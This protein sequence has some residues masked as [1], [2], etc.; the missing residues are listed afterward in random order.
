MCKCELKSWQTRESWRGRPVSN[1]IWGESGRERERDSWGAHITWV[2]GLERLSVDIVYMMFI[3]GQRKYII[4][5]ADMCQIFSDH[6]Q[7]RRHHPD[8]FSLSRAPYRL[9]LEMESFFPLWK[10]VLPQFLFSQDGLTFKH[11]DTQ[12]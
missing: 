10:T 2:R 7:Q 3:C 12:L 5:G 11:S 9:I 8:S 1:E 6:Q 4:P